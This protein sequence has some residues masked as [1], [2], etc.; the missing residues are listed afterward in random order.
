DSRQTG[1]AIR[2]QV[3]RRLTSRDEVVSYLTKHMKDEDVKK[4]QRSELVLKKFGLLPRDFDLE[5]LLVALL[6]EQIAGY[7]DPKTKTVNLLDWVP[8]EEQERVMG[9]E[10]THALQDQ[11]IG[12]DKW[13]KKGDKDL[14]EIKHDP[15]PQDIENDEMADAREA[16]VEGQAET[17]MLEYELA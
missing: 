16:V 8:M 3:K 11:T 13:M 10:L 4:L 14:G 7:Y 2:K 9:H 15:T 17:V 5:K 1:L 12:L 6:R